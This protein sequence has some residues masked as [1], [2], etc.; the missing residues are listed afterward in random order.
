M[1]R[2]QRRLAH[3]GRRGTDSRDRQQL[4]RI[5]FNFGPT[6][7][8]WLEQHAAGRLP[9]DPRG[10]PA[11]PG[12]LL[13]PRLGP[14]PGLQPHD[15]A[16]GQRAGQAHP[17]PLGHPGLRAPLR[18]RAGGMWLPETA[19]DLDTLEILAERA[20]ASP[21]SLPHQAGRVRTLGAMDKWTGTMSADGA[22]SIPAC[23]TCCRLPSGRKI[24]LFFYDGPISR[25][26]AFEGLLNNG[27]AF[28]DR[29]LGASAEDGPSPSWS[30]SPPTARP[31]A[32]TTA[33]ATWPWPTACTISRPTPWPQTDH[34]RRLPRAPSPRPTRSRSSEDTA[35]SCAHGVER[36]RS[37]CGCNIGGQG[38]AGTRPGG[39]PCGRP[40]TGCATACAP[41]SRRRW[42]TCSPTPGRPATTTSR[43]SSTAPRTRRAFLDRTAGRELAPA[44]ARSRRC[45]CSRCSATPC[46]CTPAAAGS[47]TNSPASRPPRSSAMPSRAMQLAQEVGGAELEGEFLGLLEKAP[48]NLAKYRNGAR[49]YRTAGQTDPSRPY[50]RGGPSCHCRPVRPFRAQAGL[51][52]PGPSA[53]RRTLPQRQSHP[54]RGPHPHPLGNHLERGRIRLCRPAFRR[55]QPERRHPGIRRRSG[56][57]G[58]GAGPQDLPRKG[59]HPGGFPKDGQH[60]SSHSYS[61]WHL[62]KDEQ[63][64]VLGQVLKAPLEDIEASF[65]RIYQNQANICGS[66]TRSACRFPNL[67]ATP[68]DLYLNTRLKRLLE[69]KDLDPERIREAVDEVKALGVRLDKT[70]LDF[71]AGRQITSCL[72]RLAQ[73]PD[74]LKLLQAI[75]SL[76]GILA[77]LPLKPDLWKAQNCYFAI[78]KDCREK[79]AAEES[80]GSGRAEVAGAFSQPRPLPSREPRLMRVPAGHLQTPVHARL[81]LPRGGKNRRLSQVPRHF[82][83][84]RFAHLSRQAGKP[85]RLRR[86]GPVRTEPRVGHPRKTS[87]R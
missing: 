86:G 46:S 15:H 62:F 18:A 56:I 49:V 6:L 40:S 58:H 26:V 9:G 3:P 61:L 41:A 66:C 29:L 4:R 65:G 11:E 63:R 77:P 22:A 73:N 34:L 30:T 42:P 71:V 28:A 80:V 53:R 60:F 64:R 57:H 45:A 51:L 68:V 81:H 8:S 78:W 82:G 1:L 48:S 47:S 50:P 33:T 13:R 44:R 12:A 35:W 55:T 75:D 87:L 84:L 25:A 27:E 10:R 31:T 21:S 83:H 32:T 43:S 24:A 69:R 59:G 72:V 70:I 39:P 79:V 37:D 23:P 74:D 2:A 17:G 7:L 20:C 19:V 16:P 76:M 36:W 85:P 5:S 14:R 67:L 54:C 52:L 38:R